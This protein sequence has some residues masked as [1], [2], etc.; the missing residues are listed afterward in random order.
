M[1]AAACAV[2][3]WTTALGL[4]LSLEPSTIRM[5]TDV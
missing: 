5:L 4:V 2:G 1:A 3:R